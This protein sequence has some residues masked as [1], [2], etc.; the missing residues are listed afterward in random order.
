MERQSAW[1]GLAFP[2]M[3]GA[4]AVLGG[5]ATQKGLGRDYRRLEKPPL[6]PPDWVF[7]PVWTAL[8]SMMTWSALRVWRRRGAKGRRTALALWGAQLAANAAWTPLFFAR[9]LRGWALVDL[10]ALLGLIGAY[11]AAAGKVDRTAA[12]LMLPYLGW[13]AFAGYLNAEVF[14]RN[15]PRR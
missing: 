6:H 3:T 15:R 11:V 4:A 8:Y 14:R 2:A 1:V 5:A 12:R 9:R 13:T 10:A 7:G